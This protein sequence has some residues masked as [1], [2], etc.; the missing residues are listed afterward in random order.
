MVI[1]NTVELETFEDDELHGF[2]GIDKS[3]DRKI[4]EDT[5]LEISCKIL[6]RIWQESGKIFKHFLQIILQELVRSYLIVLARIYQNLA[7]IRLYDF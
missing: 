7:R 4:Q 6:S 1:E 5:L 2:S 3:F